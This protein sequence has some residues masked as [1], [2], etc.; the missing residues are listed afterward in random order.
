[1]TARES[2]MSWDDDDAVSEDEGDTW[3]S[4]DPTVT[5]EE[6]DDEVLT[7]LFTASNPSGTVSVTSLISGQPVNV[8]LE[9]AVTRMTERELADE[10]AVVAA[11]SRQQALAAQH[12][13]ASKVLDHLGHDPVATRGFLERDLGLPSPEA[14]REERARVFASR[15]DDE[16]Y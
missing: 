1:M 14:V 11:L 2:D 5:D 9:P 12:V 13:L 15:L 3:A 4:I 8:E 16:P 7:L 10:I 6:W